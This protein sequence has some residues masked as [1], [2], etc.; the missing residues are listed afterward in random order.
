MAAALGA[1]TE[2][3]SSGTAADQGQ[4]CGVL[5][6]DLS[7]FWESSRTGTAAAAAAVA[8]AADAKV[9]CAQMPGSQPLT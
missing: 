7:S 2:R 5:P 3:R 4:P 9:L 6:P 8:A 1:A